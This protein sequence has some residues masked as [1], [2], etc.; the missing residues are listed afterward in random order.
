MTAVLIALAGVA[1]LQTVPYRGEAAC[2]V[3]PSSI[4]SRSPAG[5]AQ[6]SNLALLYMRVSTP[7]RRVPA[8][9]A[10]QGLRAEATVNQIAPDGSRTIVPSSVNATGGGGDTRA[11]YVEFVLDIPIDASE[12]DAAIKDYVSEIARAAA[13][14]TNERERAM[15]ATLQAT[16]ASTFAPLFRQHRV[17]R[18]EVECRVID[19]GRPVASGTGEF[20]LLFKGRFFDQPG[21]RAK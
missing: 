1:L 10:L 9:G 21:F 20:E 18:F 15:A 12:R 11:E 7:P 17:G 8:P 13:A 16:G 2:G 14:S 4:V 6:V 19:G 5:L 3:E